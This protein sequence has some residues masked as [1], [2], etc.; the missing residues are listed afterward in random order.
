MNFNIMFYCVIFLL[1]S[2]SKIYGNTMFYF[3]V[4]TEGIYTFKIPNKLS[5][6]EL[7]VLFKNHYYRVF[8]ENNYGYVYC[9]EKGYYQISSNYK[10]PL[11]PFSISSVLKIE[12]RN[13]Y[14][15]SLPNSLNSSHWFLDI[16][17]EDKPF[18]KKVFKGESLKDKNEY[19]KL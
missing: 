13:H 12:E 3:N 18:K 1:A 4:A 10:K 19:V 15:Y 14:K 11:Q 6:K 9:P 17:S 8:T 5:D 2:S 7:F 16:I